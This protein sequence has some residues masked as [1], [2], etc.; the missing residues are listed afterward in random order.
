MD[1]DM[2]ANDLPVAGSA[3]TQSRRRGRKHRG[4]PSALKRQ[5]AYRARKNEAT[6]A[7]YRKGILERLKVPQFDALV[8]YVE[9]LES[10]AEPDAKILPVTTRSAGL[11]SSLSI[12]IANSLDSRFIELDFDVHAL[13]R[14]TLTLQA[15][16]LDYAESHQRHRTGAVSQVEYQ[17]VELSAEF[18]NEAIKVQEVFSVLSFAIAPLGVFEHASIQYVTA[19]RAPHH[20]HDRPD[21]SGPTVHSKRHRAAIRTRVPDPFTITILNLRSAVEY[22]SD[23]ATDHASRLY[24]RRWCPI[25][26]ACWND[27]NVLTNPDE[28]IPDGYVDDPALLRRD[29]FRYRGYMSQIKKKCGAF[30]IPF[31]ASGVGDVRSLVGVCHGANGPFLRTEAKMVANRLVSDVVCPSRLDFHS[32]APLENLEFVS[33][34]IGLLGEHPPHGPSRI[35]TE[36]GDGYGMRSPSNS[37]CTRTLD[38]LGIADAVFSVR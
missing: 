12:S 20:A 28:V 33:G 21:A 25:P 18:K 22:L 7:D 36:S 8:E 35:D 26:G 30:I 5:D 17:T 34:A 13:Y 10:R 9:R 31:N 32:I 4:K 1:V 23:R 3:A 15:L 16:Q 24:F 38:Y 11:L 37:A 14:I 19:L 29:L 27:D 2:D 6:L